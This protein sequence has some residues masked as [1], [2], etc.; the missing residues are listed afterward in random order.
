M[1]RT[2]RCLLTILLPGLCAAQQPANMQSV[3]WVLSRIALDL[4]VDY[5]RHAVDGT[6]TLTLRNASTSATH[7]VPLLINR[8][9]SVMRVTDTTG[10]QLRFDQRVVQFRDDSVWQATSINVALPRPV[11][12]GDLTTITVR[13]GGILVGYAETGSR[14]IRDAVSRDFTI[15]RADAFAFPTLGVPFWS[16]MRSRPR[17]PFSFDLRLRVPA[18]LTVAAAGELVDTAKTDSSVVWSYRS[19]EPVPFLNIAIAPYDVITG[20]GTK[21]FFFPAD[22]SGARTLQRAAKAAVDHMSRSYGAVEL[23]HA[24]VVTEIP[25]GFGSQASLTG[26]IIQTADAFQSRRELRQVYHELSHLWN[27]PDLDRPSPR[28]NEG[29]ASFM[30]WRLAEELDGSTERAAQIERAFA[31]LRA[32]C[33]GPCAST[34]LSEYGARG[35]TDLSYPVGMLMFEALY[36][37]LGA[38]RFDTTYARF[39]QA[40]RD[41]GGRMTDLIAAFA[42]SDPRTRRIFSEWATS[43]RWNERLRGGETFAAIVSSYR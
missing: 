22:S 19:L 36:S 41:A 7:Q 14:Y 23:R 12:P 31:S 40:H 34:P 43:T 20:A 18:G 6:T 4:R 3:P 16:G 42:E 11:P 2:S 8:L 33:I 13:S 32:R 27:P 15:L 17:D 21:I 25:E 35:L 37:V 29:F 5:V 38:D 9:M 26:G 39:F 28:W 10:A 24:L 1:T 30:Q